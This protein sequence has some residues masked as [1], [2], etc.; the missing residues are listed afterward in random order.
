M[1]DPA[2]A[3]THRPDLRMGYFGEAAFSA[4]SNFS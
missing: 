2:D 3:A 4:S 1:D